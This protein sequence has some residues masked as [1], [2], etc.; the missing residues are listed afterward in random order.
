L[1]CEQKAHAF[2]VDTLKSMRDPAVRSILEE[3]RDEEVRH[4]DLVGR[5]LEKL[6]PEREAEID[7]ESFTDEPTS[8]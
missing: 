8:Q 1:R 7:P 6:A 5:E 3:L 4:Q 2:F